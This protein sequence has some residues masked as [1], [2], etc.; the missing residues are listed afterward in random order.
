VACYA[1][2]GVESLGSAT[3]DLDNS[4][5]GRAVIGCEDG[6]WI[7]LTQD[8]ASILATLYHRFADHSGR[9]V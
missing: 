6:R 1:T 7:Q 2:S 9:A 4:K 5:M 3:R 8:C